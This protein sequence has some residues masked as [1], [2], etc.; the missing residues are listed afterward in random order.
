MR[1]FEGVDSRAFGLLF[2]TLL[3]AVAEEQTSKAAGTVEY[4]PVATPKPNRFGAPWGP[5]RIQCRQIWINAVKRAKSAIY[6]HYI[7][8]DGFL[9]V[10]FDSILGVNVFEVGRSV[11]V[12]CDDSLETHQ[13]LTPL[14]LTAPRTH[15][16]WTKLY[17]CLWSLGVVTGVS[18][19]SASAVAERTVVCIFS[20]IT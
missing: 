3:S 18:V 2:L 7:T 4:R 9:Y 14:L 11:W 5:W 15:L 20:I 8:Q 16:V 1:H 19:Y 17:G 6:L 12:Q 10:L 13:S